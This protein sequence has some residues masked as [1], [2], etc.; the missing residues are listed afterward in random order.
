MYSIN[1]VAVP[2]CVEAKMTKEIWNDSLLVKDSAIFKRLEDKLKRNVSGIRV[3]NDKS[4]VQTKRQ[5]VRII[6]R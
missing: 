2:L 3:Q 1:F 6:Q 5:V 4:V